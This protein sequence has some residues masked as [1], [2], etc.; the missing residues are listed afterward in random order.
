MVT[1][2]EAILLFKERMLENVI[3]LLESGE[4]DIE[5]AHAQQ[6]QL[7]DEIQALRAEIA[8]EKKKK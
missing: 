3:K 6:K 8:E 5:T 2:K 1:L 4:M 7:E